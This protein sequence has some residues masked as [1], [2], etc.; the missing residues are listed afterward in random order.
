MRAQAKG[1][2][3]IRRTKQLQGVGV[4]I[5]GR[6][7]VCRADAQGDQAAGL[8]SHTGQ[9]KVL[10]AASI[11]KLVGGLEAQKLFDGQIK[12]AILLLGVGLRGVQAGQQLLALVRPLLQRR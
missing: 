1:Q 3:P 5:H 9:F 12:Q 2:V 4:F 10:H 8:E 11:A 6:V 7:P